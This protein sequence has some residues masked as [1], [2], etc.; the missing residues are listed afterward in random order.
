[1]RPGDPG[2]GVRELADAAV[3]HFAGLAPADKQRL[4]FAF[5]M[6]AVYGDKDGLFFNL[7]QSRF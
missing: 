1:M 3:I 5:H 4:A 6:M 2:V 7:A